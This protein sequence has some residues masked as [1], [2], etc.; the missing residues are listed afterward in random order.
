MSQFKFLNET[1]DKQSDNAAQSFLDEKLSKN[2]YTI[3]QQGILDANGGPSHHEDTKYNTIV[4]NQEEIDNFESSG[5]LAA[6]YEA[7]Y[8]SNAHADLSG[9]HDAASANQIYDKIKALESDEYWASQDLSNLMSKAGHKD[10]RVNIGNYIKDGGFA[11]DASIQ[12]GINFENI[13]GKLDDKGW[14]GEKNN[15]IGQLGSALLAADGTGGSKPPKP[16]YEDVPIE[17]SPE[18]KQA[19]QRVAAYENGILSGKTSDDIYKVKDQYSFDAM[20]GAAGIGTP[21]S[22]GSA[23]QAGKATKSFLDNK[24]SQLKDKYQFQALS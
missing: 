18:I 9:A 7:K 14:N 3:K 16:K 2:K 17:H 20:K 21:M 15:S 11:V 8:G 24:K 23:Q 6:R 12:N 5:D 10:T 1:P 19:Q 22:G 4:S 13:Q